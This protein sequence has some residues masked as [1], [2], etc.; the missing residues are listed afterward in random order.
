[1][2]AAA[3]ALAGHAAGCCDE[4]G[5][6][7][8]SRLGGEPRARRSRHRPRPRPPPPRARAR[9]GTSAPRQQ[10][11]RGA[12]IKRFLR[13][14]SWRNFQVRYP[15]TEGHRSVGIRLFSWY[16]HRVIGLTAS[17]PLVAVAFFQV[18][19]LLTPLRSLFEP[20]IVWAVLSRDMLSRRH[21]LAGPRPRDV[22]SSPASM[23]PLDEGTRKRNMV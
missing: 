19:H 10:Q 17:H 5:A 12:E 18:W 4:A 21:K 3:R 15:E 1:V 9:P 11:P 16:L 23:P 7:L 2:V 20:R 22:A 14:G 8:V 13:A 6:L